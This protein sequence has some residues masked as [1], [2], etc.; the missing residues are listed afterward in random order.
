MRSRCLRLALPVVVCLRL[1]LCSVCKVSVMG[2]V[3]VL[4]IEV[5]VAGCGKLK[6]VRVLDVSEEAASKVKLSLLSL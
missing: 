2:M 4:R 1:T 6:C 5:Q 3:V